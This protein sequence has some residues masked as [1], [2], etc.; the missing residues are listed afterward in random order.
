MEVVGRVRL[1]GGTRLIQSVNNN[2]NN[3]WGRVNQ[4]DVAR[5]RRHVSVPRASFEDRSNVNSAATASTP[6]YDSVDD[7]IGVTCVGFSTRGID[8][9]RRLHESGGM[10]AASTT[11]WCLDTDANVIESTKGFSESILMDE[12]SLSPQDVRRIIGRTASDAGGQGNIGSGDGCLAFVLSP[13]TGIAEESLLQLTHS[14]RAAGHFTVAA[15]VSPFDFEGPLKKNQSKQLVAELSKLAHV[16]VVLEQDVLLKQSYGDDKTLTVSESTE[17]AISALEHTVR[18]IVQAVNAS[19]MLKSTQGGLMWHGKELRHFKRLISPPLQH[20]LTQKGLGVLGRGRALLPQKAA[21]S[22][23]HSAALMHLASEAVAGAAESPFIEGVIDRAGGVLCCLRIPDD[24]SLKALLGDSAVGSHE[25]IDRA[26]KLAAQ[27][28]AGALR[29]MT[30][31]G[32]DEFLVYIEKYRCS[33][34]MSGGSINVEAT[35]LVLWSDENIS[36]TKASWKSSWDINLGD[37]NQKTTAPTKK[38]SVGSKNADG[39]VEAKKS[40]GMLSALA[41]GDQAKKGAAASPPPVVKRPVVVKPTPEEKEKRRMKDNVTVGDYLAESL[42]AQSLDLPPA[43]AR[44]RQ[45]H[46]SGQLKQRR[47]VV[48]EVDEDEPWESEDSKPKN[49]L[50]ALLS[51]DR[52]G[53]DK[54]KKV[55]VRDRVAGVLAQDRD[56]A[57]EAEV[58][59]SF[60]DKNNI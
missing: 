7:S 43:A 51:G 44:W 18:C 8:A 2:N 17:I 26:C 38:P 58:R 30:G 34:D 32:C 15:V 56:E 39:D 21:M 19:E 40:W 22:M 37:G 59:D 47:L 35:M 23:G 14:F 12:R 6:S 24:D 50:K 45:E 41:G 57:W 3:V 53:G 33:E 52:R 16:V 29:S 36:A 27:A 20:L 5:R 60:Q 4:R 55:N 25:E 42:T 10:P 46:R 49:P 48:W 9:L 11:M 28:S 13:S 31:S 1:C 54:P